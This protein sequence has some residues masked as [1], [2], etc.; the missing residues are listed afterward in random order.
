M[1]A[2]FINPRIYKDVHQAVEI[3]QSVPVDRKLC[4][5]AFHFPPCPVHT[6][7]GVSPGVSVGELWILNALCFFW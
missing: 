1:N 7:R 4:N 5:V 6:A 3:T 2:T